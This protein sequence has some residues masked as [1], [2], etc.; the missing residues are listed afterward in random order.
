MANGSDINVKEM[1]GLHHTMFRCSIN[2]CLK[3][4]IT[5]QEWRMNYYDVQ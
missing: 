1:G 2:I 5:R 3:G 4:E